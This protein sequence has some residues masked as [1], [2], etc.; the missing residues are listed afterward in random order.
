[1]AQQIVLD[2]LINN[3]Q[4]ANSIKETR[5]ALKGLKEALAFNIDEKDI[6]SVKRAQEA[7]K[8]LKDKV[9]DVNDSLK[10]NA[11]D[12][13]T[14]VGDQFKYVKD[15]IF[16]LDFSKATSGLNNLKTSV[17]SINFSSI[18][19]GVKLFGESLGQL[20]KAVYSA[21]GPWGLLAAAVV[22]IIGVLYSLK[23]IIKPIGDAFN[24]LGRVFD[25]VVQKFR[26]FSDAVFGTNLVAQN[27]AKET[28][29][30]AQYEEEV[31]RQSYDNRIKLME[32]NRQNAFAERQKEY[33]ELNTLLNN[34]VQAYKTA[35]EIQLNDIKK[36]N[37]ENLRLGRELNFGLSDEQI[38][39]QEEY[40]K[41]TKVF[42]DNQTE[43]QVAQAN[44][45]IRIEK[46]NLQLQTDAYLAS[47]NSRIVVMK[48]EHAKSIAAENTRFNAQKKQYQQYFLDNKLDPEQQNLYIETK[49]REHNNILLGI[50]KTF[51]E[52]ERLALIQQENIR[53]STLELYQTKD[54]DILNQISKLRLD[55]IDKE[56]KAKL[57]TL[58]KGSEQYIA[59]QKDAE[60]KRAQ[61]VKDTNDGIKKINDDYFNSYYKNVSNFNDVT[62]TQSVGIINKIRGLAKPL[63]GVSPAETTTLTTKD[64]F[65]PGFSVLPSKE[66]Y[67]ETGG[68]YAQRLKSVEKKLKQDYED[69]LYVLDKPLQDKY[70]DFF[71]FFQNN[72][73]KSIEK[74][75]GY[76]TG[77]FIKD[78]KEKGKNINDATVKT[79][80]ENITNIS[81]E[82]VDKYKNLEGINILGL[83]TGEK[84][85]IGTKVNVEN[86]NFLDNQ[87]NLN[88]NRQKEHY[89]KLYQLKLDDLQKDKEIALAKAKTSEEY[90]RIESEFILKSAEAKEQKR[91]EN[92][93]LEITHNNQLKTL[94]Q[95]LYQ[96]ISDIADIFY[97]IKSDNARGDVEKEQKIAEEKFNIN[98]AFMLSIAIP[99]QALN[100][101]NAWKGIAAA[102]TPIEKAIAIA[103]FSATVAG[104]ALQ[105]SKIST[106]RFQRT[107]SSSSV[108]SSA[109]P[110]NLYGQ[111]NN[112]NNLG[113][114]NPNTNQ[115]IKVYVLE[116]EIS[117]SQTS[118]NRYKT[119]VQLG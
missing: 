54:V 32:A 57:L 80:I 84:D 75:S 89:D 96:G 65:F 23:D 7:Y 10:A 116:S 86:K 58:K 2:I 51:K 76:S 60:L 92:I 78:L 22:A 61:N 109:P 50:D 97:T 53:I 115:Q 64:K 103:T 91:Q 81:N 79:F 69:A 106:S 62:Y 68:L 43:Q 39:I 85:V 45:R 47:S 41:K 56:E 28:L 104:S 25:S 21:L 66:I 107:Q 31:L 93:Q 77:Q 59:A 14:R 105:I 74:G 113:V 87:L 40:L 35:N 108:T 5:L 24:F 19:Q 82:M 42:D 99:Q 33:N 12:G 20:G 67:G 111:G 101:L 6:E 110:I 94:S 112:V 73:S 30:N 46:L 100:I 63:Q 72:Y 34:Q 29:K 83:K 13:L 11:Q 114:Q 15:R 48:D 55:I 27:T 4:A 102:I 17:S 26:E 16:E 70:P 38:K 98:K 49:Q 88:F 119:N 8:N 36:R 117:A 44:E 71:N 1:M 95:D 118:V 3:A 9:D 52:N 90:Q 37:E 18:S